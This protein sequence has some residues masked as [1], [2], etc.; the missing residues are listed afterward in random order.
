MNNKKISVK[1]SYLL[2]SLIKP[3][4]IFCQ[5]LGLNTAEKILIKSSFINIFLKLYSII[6]ILSTSIIFFLLDNKPI[7]NKNINTIV[8]IAKR[9][10][11]NIDFF[12]LIWDLLI[13]LYR[14]KQFQ[15]V[16]F[17]L[18]HTEQVLINEL[19]QKLNYKQLY[20]FLYIFISIFLIIDIII[21]ILQYSLHNII[22]QFSLFVNNLSVLLFCTLLLI[23]SK[24]FQILNK[25]LF[26]FNGKNFEKIQKIRELHL[27]LNDTVVQLNSTNTL[28]ILVRFSIIFVHIFQTVYE[29]LFGFII[30]GELIYNWKIVFFSSYSLIVDLLKLFLIALSSEHVVNT[31]KEMAIIVHKLT[32]SLT[33]IDL[34]M[35]HLVSICFCYT[36]NILS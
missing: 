18:L 35:K 15:Q 12:L 7:F 6:I 8:T 9:C 22:F 23:I 31:S 26:K 3:L 33:T 16:Y 10:T 13:H 34:K 1:N 27:L 32:F 17:N 24:Y 11:R 30:D 14:S 4:I 21:F 36:L 29:L 2:N 19:K 25:I 28:Q 20:T 5:I